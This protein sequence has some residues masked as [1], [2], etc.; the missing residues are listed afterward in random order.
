[1]TDPVVIQSSVEIRRAPEEVFAFAST[2][3]NWPVWHPTALSVEGDVAGP[4]KPG[5]RILEQDR[6]LFLRGQIRWQAHAV[7][8]PRSWTIEGVVEG[9]PMFS[10]TTTTV[11]YTVTPV[12]EGARI[13]RTMHYRPSTA[14]GRAL[15]WLIFRRHNRHQSQHALDAIKRLLDVPPL[16]SGPA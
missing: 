14:V 7:D 4:L 6:F 11:S 1:M 3:A 9:I 12:A 5:D 2:P 15:D 10:G 8:A 16:G 13:D